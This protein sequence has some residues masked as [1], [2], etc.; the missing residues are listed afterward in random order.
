M[1]R[2]SRLSHDC[3]ATVEYE[4][5]KKLAY[6]SNLCQDDSDVMEGASN[7]SNEYVESSYEGIYGMLGRLFWENDEIIEQ[8]VQMIWSYTDGLV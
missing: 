3:R 5:I 2:R 4:T 6:S 7:P 1:V 8:W